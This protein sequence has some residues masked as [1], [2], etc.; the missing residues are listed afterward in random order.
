MC[1]ASPAVPAPRAQAGAQAGAGEA[2]DKACGKIGEAL[3][4]GHRRGP[5]TR[6]SHRRL[7]KH[8]SGAL[9]G[10]GA[11]SCGAGPTG[12]WVRSAPRPFPARPPL[13]SEQ[14]GA[15]CPHCPLFC[16]QRDLPPVGKGALG[17]EAG[18][19]LPSALRQASR[20]PG[21]G[22]AGSVSGPELAALLLL[23]AFAS[24]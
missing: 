7:G 13:C 11:A 3:G 8:P 18:L 9:L 4:L 10:T 16:F 19:R 23:V 21:R 22:P 24:K 6:G 20:E 1:R 5:M 2:G 15:S 12:C 17:T 14:R